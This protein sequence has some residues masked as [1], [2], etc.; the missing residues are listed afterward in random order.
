MGDKGVL[1]DPGVVGEKGELGT[2]GLPGDQ[3]GVGD[4]GV[5]GQMGSKGNKRSISFSIYKEKHGLKRKIIYQN[6]PNDFSIF[7][8]RI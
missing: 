5:K 2:S 7:N 4:A 6:V 8:R 1:G 3:G